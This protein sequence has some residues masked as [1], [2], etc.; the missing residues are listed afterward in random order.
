V[1]RLHSAIAFNSIDD[2]QLQPWHLKLSFQ[3]FDVKGEASEKGTIEEWWAGPSSYKVVYTSPSFTG[4]EIHTKDGVFR[5]KGMISAPDLLEK[6]LRQVVHPIRSEQGI[7]PSNPTLQLHDF[8][9]LKMDCIMLVQK[10]KNISDPPLGFFPTYCLDHDNDRLRISYD[11][12][13]QVTIRGRIGVFQERRVVIDQ[14]ISEGPINTITAH[15]EALEVVTTFAGGLDPSS[16][17]E[18]VGDKPVAIDSE[19]V[20]GKRITGDV[21]IYPLDAKRR[22]VSGEVV[23]A[24]RIG[25]DGRIHSLRVVSAPATD[26]AIASIVAVRK[27]TYTPFLLDGRP[28]DVTSTIKLNFNFGPAN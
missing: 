26:L 14:T 5:S 2:P 28:T 21:P 27:W 16:D 23:L 20:R 15:L 22:H 3:L 24:A 4:T 10:I 13:S 19:L 17:M 1:D 12:G 6:V 18:K 25:G 9:N 7:V 11:F 8:G